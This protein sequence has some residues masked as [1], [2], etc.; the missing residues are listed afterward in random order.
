MR[1]VHLLFEQL[2]GTRPHLEEE[3]RLGVTRGFGTV[4]V[5]VVHALYDELVTDGIYRCCRHPLYASWVVFIVPGI[6]FLVNSW[7]GLTIPIFMYFVLR[8]LVR[9]EEIYLASVF[10]SEYSDYKKRVPCI[11]PYGML[12]LK[13]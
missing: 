9:K 1:L 4:V 10:G 3:P 2:G 12:G 5:D 7:I 8:I 13:D 6:V 11:L